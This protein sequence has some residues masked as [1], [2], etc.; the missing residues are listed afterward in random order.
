MEAQETVDIKPSMSK[1]KNSECLIILDF[2]LY[3][4]VIVT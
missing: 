1:K 3:Y 4:R 2:K